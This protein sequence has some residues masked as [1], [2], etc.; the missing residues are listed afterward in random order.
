MLHETWVSSTAFYCRCSKETIMRLRDEA[1]HDTVISLE[2]GSA[3]T[4]FV[5]VRTSTAG[6]CQ[7][8]LRMASPRACC[9]AS[10]ILKQ[11]VPTTACCV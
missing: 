9:K 5:L 7:W 2:L 8:R 3:G 4:L 6:V 10:L 1:V 11:V